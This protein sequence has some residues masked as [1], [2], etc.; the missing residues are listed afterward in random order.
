MNFSVELKLGT[1]LLT[2]LQNY[3]CLSSKPFFKIDILKDS[4]KLS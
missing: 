2:L 3:E 1:Y 4:S